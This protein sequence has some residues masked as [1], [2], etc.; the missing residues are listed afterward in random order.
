MGR[1]ADKVAERKREM[2]RS[3]WQWYDQMMR[4]RRRE[5][6]GGRQMVR[7]APKPIDDWSKRLHTIENLEACK[8]V[9]EREGE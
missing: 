8:P 9:A 4:Q 2:D 1:E 3:Y 6:R 7:S 5:R